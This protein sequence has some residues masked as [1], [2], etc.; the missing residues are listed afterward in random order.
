[1][2]GTYP[3]AGSF[4]ARSDTRTLG[5]N[6]SPPAR[7]AEKRTRHPER[8]SVLSRRSD[9]ATPTTPDRL[10]ATAGSMWSRRR[11]RSEGDWSSLTTMGFDQDSPLSEE[12][13]SSTSHRPDRRSGQVRDS[14]SR[15]G[16]PL[17]STAG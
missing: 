10:T 16:P 12:D 9:Q 2:I 6:L 7:E 17:G 13:E 4:C 3:P 1:M 8:L 15:K 11:S 14:R 5:V